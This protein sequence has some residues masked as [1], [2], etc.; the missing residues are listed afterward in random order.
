MATCKVRRLHRC[1]WKSKL[2][3]EVT[4]MKRKYRV[5]TP[6]L[7][8][9]AGILVALSLDGAQVPAAAPPSGQVDILHQLSLGEIAR[10][11]RAER[12]QQHEQ[13]AKVYTNDNLPTRDSGLSIIG[14][15]APAP[16]EP[17][18][19]GESLPPHGE[20]YYRNK[21]NE[22]RQRLETDQRELAVLQQ[23]LGNNQIQ[24]YPNPNETLQQEY[25]RS[26][27]AKLQQQIAEK[28][29]QVAADEKAISDLADQ[30]RR[31]GGEPGWLREGPAAEAAG[32]P[33]AGSAAPAPQPTEAQ[34]KSREYWQGRFREAR[35]ALAQAQEQRKLTEDELQLLKSQQAHE[36]ADAAAAAA[37]QARID[38]K[39]F[40]LEQRQAAVEKAQRALDELEKEFRE[41]G[42]PPDWSRTD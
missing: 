3:E 8:F 40:E 19:A 30:L 26:D 5:S 42:A 4:D 12:A 21:M 1:F 2:K 11:L 7:G 27:I 31:E 25:S 14:S 34:K 29:R 35:A 6:W 16:S 9:G 18:A 37:L 41:S 39:Q 13:P 10:K 17:G 20:T 38:A 22:L 15:S 36:A 28:Q 33:G 24:Y 23:E 32:S